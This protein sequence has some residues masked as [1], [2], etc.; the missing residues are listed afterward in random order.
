[1]DFLIN[2]DK[3]KSEIDI[4]QYFLFKMGSL[5]SFDKYKR[6]YVSDSN[7]N[8]G[9]IIRFFYHEKSGIKMYYSIVFQDSGDIIQFIKKRILQNTNAS[10][11][12]INQELKGYLG[13]GDVNQQIKYKTVHFENK[14]PKDTNYQIHGDIIQKIEQHYHYLLNYRKLSQTALQS[15]LFVDVFFT[16]K[17]NSNESLAFYLKDVNDRVVGI[18]RIQTQENEFFNKKWFDKSSQNRV[19]FTFSN[20]LPDT[21]TL[22]IF[23]SIFDAISFH[24][25]YKP[26]STQYCST[27]GELSFRKAN[28]LAEYFGKNNF[29]KLILGN[30]NDLAGNYF[31]LNIIGSFIKE[32]TNIRKSENNI[33]IELQSVTGEKKTN[34]LLQFF[35][36]S[37][38]KFA[39]DDKNDFPQSY[40]T[41]TLS[42]NSNI[43]F[44]MISNT[45]ES[46]QFFVGLLMRAWNLENTITIYQPISKDFNEDLIN[47]KN[48]THG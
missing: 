10:P 19:G 2:W 4:E 40:F 46:I 18:N 12:E 14:Q 20:K 48:T 31:N 42:N 37:T 24:E 8:H 47:L 23:E 13:L 36:K 34:V 27:N 38:Q 11:E 45:Q 41:E 9:D 28:L 16:Y 43:Y 5:F 6:A 22:S 21:E 1:M 3:I 15:Q 30:D 17:S 26:E 33:C 35:K 29:R 44:F 32:I 39:L 25:I 7:E